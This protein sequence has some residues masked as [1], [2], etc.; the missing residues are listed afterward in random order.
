MV[1]YR[2]NPRQP[3]TFKLKAMKAN[4]LRIGNLFTHAN[5]N[6]TFN[7]VVK[8]VLESGINTHFNNGTWFIGLDNIRPIP[9]TE[10]ILIKA[11]GKKIPHMTVT[12][13]I[14]FDLD[15][16]RFLSIGCVEDCNQMAWIQHIDGRKVTDLVCV[17]NYDYDGWL[18]LHDLQNLIFALTGEEI[19]IELE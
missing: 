10:E 6:G 17:H 7:I 13:S 2:F 4:E 12:N 3:R 15:R 8:E 9:L 1:C 11:G 14:L 16:D 5:E 19:K 18:Y